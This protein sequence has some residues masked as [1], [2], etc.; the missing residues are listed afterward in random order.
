MYIGQFVV[1]GGARWPRLRG[2]VVLEVVV[3]SMFLCCTE[4]D[5]VVLPRQ[6][7]Q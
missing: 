2:R 4:C 1:E 5:V 7:A 3:V 6:A